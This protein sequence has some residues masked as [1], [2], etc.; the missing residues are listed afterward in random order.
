MTGHSLN[1]SSDQLPFYNPQSRNNVQL[2]RF[3][4]LFRSSQ[5]S[6]N[7]AHSSSCPNLKNQTIN[8]QK[9]EKKK[10]KANFP[11]LFVKGS[12]YTPTRLLGAGAYSIVCEAIDIRT[13]TLVAIKKISKVFNNHKEAIRTLREIKLMHHFNHNENI[14]SIRDV[15]LPKTANKFQN[16]LIVLE[17]ME[18]DLSDKITKSGRLSRS[19][20]QQI[21]FKIINGLYQIHNSNV[22]HRD[23][24]PKNVLLNNNDND[25]VI[26]DFGMG[27]SI[28]LNLSLLSFTTATLYTPPEGLFSISQYGKGVDVWAI[29]CIFAEMIIGDRLVRGKTHNDIIKFVLQLVGV[30][31][32]Q[33]IDLLISDPI[34]N[35]LAK[36]LRAEIISS[37]SLNNRSINRNDNNTDNNMQNNSPTMVSQLNRSTSSLFNSSEDNNKIEQNSSFDSKLFSSF[38]KPNFESEE[39]DDVAYRI[40]EDELDLLRKIFTFNPSDRIST[41]DLLSHP[42]FDELKDDHYHEFA[43]NNNEKPL[44]VYEDGDLDLLNTTQLQKVVYDRL[45]E[46]FPHS[47]YPI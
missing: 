14:L 44:F 21:I 47:V 18:Y 42:Y 9:Q 17:K 35:Q 20:R 43:S 5:S 37:S 36:T 12:N 39:E 3:K 24:R 16:L 23:L 41:A 22:I 11:E 15:L 30:P 7:L 27:R 25:V 38:F 29:G 6:S 46:L 19:E 34:K 45:L 4:E 13:N 8:K 10:L 33:Q 1:Q 26:C 31:S 32:V 28:G 40:D 2:L